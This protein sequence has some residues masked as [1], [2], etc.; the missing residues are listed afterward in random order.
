MELDRFFA[1]FGA[2][3][4]DTGAEGTVRMAVVG[5]GGFGLGAGVPA[6]RASDYCEF[7]VGVSGTPE[8]RREVADE[9]GV[10]TID[11]EEY[12]AGAAA[13]AYDAVY[14]AT[15]NRL[16]LP[17]AEAA[18]EHGKDVLCEKPLEATPERAAR[19][20]DACEGVTLMTAYRMQTDPVVRRLRALLRSGAVGDPTRLFGNFTFDVLGGSRGPDQWRLDADLAGGGALMDVGVYPLNTA[21]FLLGTD[22]E[23]VWATVRSEGAAFDDVDEHVD[24]GVVFPDCVGSFA[25][26]FS[27]AADARFAVLCTDGS[28]RVTDAF[29]VNAD[30]TVVVETP[31]GRAEFEGLGA[32][33]TVEEFDYFGNCVLTGGDPEPD[34]TDGV[35]DV[36]TA[37][38]VYE[39]AA[40]GGR[41]TL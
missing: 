25:A 12:A 19:L 37:A 7:A 24:F 18:A 40:S 9:H 38:R 29:G 11:Y 15:P 27:G 35:V 21:R 16:H 36:R 10:R 31:R 3:D 32:D 13:D 26:S 33:E 28:V 2:R 30:R 39:A 23:A 41:V 6:I 22:P 34:G 4:W 1:D 5:L 20:V 17:H 8:T 14:I